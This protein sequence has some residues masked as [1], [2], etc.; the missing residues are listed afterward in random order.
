MEQHPV[1]QQISSYQ[2][3][4]VGDMTLKQFL[5]LAGGCLVSLLF[6]AS[7][8]HPIIKWPAIL[9]FALLGAALAFLPFQERSLE[10]WIIAFFRSVYSPTL[11]FWR[12]S[13]K[14]PIFFREERPAPK[15]EIII[16]HGEKAAE[17]YL[18]TLPQLKSPF[19]TK[20]E[21]SEQ[22]F[23]SK[24]TALLT[25]ILPSAPQ[26]TVQVPQKTIPIPKSPKPPKA[27]FV[28]EETSAPAQVGVIQP[29]T[30]MVEQT[31]KGQRAIGAQLPQFSLEAAP[32]NPPT[33]PNTVV[34]QVMTPEAKIVEGAILEIKD[35][36]GRPV[37]AF[38]TNK[39]GHFLALT[40]L[41]NGT[42]ELITEK[43]GLI[44]S[45]LKF[46]AKGS[47]I[48]PIAVKAKARE[49]SVEVVN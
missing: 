39:A 26:K 2:F 40:P 34:G 22:S 29:Q 32:P 17:T 49:R 46:E 15:E 48:P 25:S 10:K 38:K 47:I 27:G 16:P 5:Q 6:Y 45:P 9:F 11:Y 21:T 35:A 8:L 3:R 19:L 13:K 24:I 4:L 18:A 1:P 41:I 23:L 44:F 14:P 31:L 42:Y 36:Q 7:P 20:L 43:E 12:G 37:R 28:V 30:T 33:R